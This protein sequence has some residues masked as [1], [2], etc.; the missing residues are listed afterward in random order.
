M[1]TTAKP[2]IKAN[3]PHHYLNKNCLLLTLEQKRCVSSTEGSRSM[4]LDT[5]S[6]VKNLHRSTADSQYFNLKVFVSFQVQ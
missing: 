2:Y 3:F 6:A 5:F 4:Y 1:E